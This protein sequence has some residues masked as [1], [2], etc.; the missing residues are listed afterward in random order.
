MNRAIDNVA[1]ETVVGEVSDIVEWLTEKKDE[2]EAMEIDFDWELTQL[3]DGR[4]RIEI[5]LEEEE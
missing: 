3:S 5:I 2:L 1:T 4:I